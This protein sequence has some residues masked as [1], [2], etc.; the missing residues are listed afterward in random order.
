VEQ[1]TAN[2]EIRFWGNFVNSI[3]YFLFTLSTISRSLS[4][5]YGSFRLIL[6]VVVYYESRSRDIGNKSIVFFY[7]TPFCASRSHTPGILSQ[8]T[9]RVV[10]VGLWAR[11]NFCETTSRY[12]ERRAQSLCDFVFHILYRDVSTLF[13]FRL[14]Q[15][16][17]SRVYINASA[18]RGQRSLRRELPP[19]CLLFYFSIY[20]CSCSSARRITITIQHADGTMSQSGVQGCNFL[21]P[22]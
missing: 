7:S 18:S 8:Y 12:Y 1:L 6:Y 4:F 17:P 2:K 11:P 15:A 20:M 5:H 14:I 22:Q 16:F 21:F 13:S 9:I 10:V 19:M 3:N